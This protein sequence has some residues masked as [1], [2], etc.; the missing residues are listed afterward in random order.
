MSIQN[1]YSN[2]YSFEYKGCVSV[3]TKPIGNKDS[4]LWKKYIHL[5]LTTTK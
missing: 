2:N 5:R 3:N 1:F 4:F